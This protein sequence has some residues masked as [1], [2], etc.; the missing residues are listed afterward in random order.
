MTKTDIVEKVCEGRGISKSEAAEAVDAVFELMKGTLESGDDLKISGFGSFTVRK[1]SARRGRN[2]QT[3]EDITI[4]NR[5]VVTFKLSTTLKQ[6]I[7]Q[8]P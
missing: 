7:N 4:A 8:L 3:G 2:P 5:N 6:E 1:K